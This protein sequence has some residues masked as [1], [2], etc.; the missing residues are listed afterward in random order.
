MKF[1]L[2]HAVPAVEPN[3]IK[4]KLWKKASTHIKFF[5][6]DAWPSEMG[7]ALTLIQK[8][9]DVNNL[10]FNA[11]L[12][13]SQGTSLAIGDGGPVKP[14]K[15]RRKKMHTKLGEAKL[16]EGFYLHCKFLRK[17]SEERGFEKRMEKWDAIC[18]SDRA[19]GV[20]DSINQPTNTVP[21]AYQELD[22]WDASG[23]LAFECMVSAGLLRANGATTSPSSVAELP[24]LQPGNQGHVGV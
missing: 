14:E 20:E 17:L 4:P 10:L 2:N 16:M 19:T 7:T 6:K 21:R 15:K 1:L 24:P 23:N 13:D 5:G 3:V 12:I 18:C 22:I 8:F 9:S 11:G